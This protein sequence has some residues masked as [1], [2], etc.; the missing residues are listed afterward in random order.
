MA[1][2]TEP[3]MMIHLSKYLQVKLEEIHPSGALGEQHNCPLCAKEF[4]SLNY[5]KTHLVTH[6][7]L[8]KALASF[9]P[10]KGGI[11]RALMVL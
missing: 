11:T 9:I 7:R 10:L 1:L 5:L 8:A 6:Y 2:V 3:R 4:A